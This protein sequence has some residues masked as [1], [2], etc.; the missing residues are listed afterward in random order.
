MTTIQ[1]LEERLDAFEASLLQMAQNNVPV[2]E[3]ADTAYN[4]CPQIDRNT[5]G[6]EENSDGLIDVADLA[7][8]NSSCIEE[9]ADL[10][11]DLEERVAALE[12]KEA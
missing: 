3:R 2:T 4:K 8:E 1:D 5:G 6:V 11:E 7:D 9:L 12:E 10:I